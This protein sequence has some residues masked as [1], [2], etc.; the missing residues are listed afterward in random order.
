MP[1]A[2]VRRPIRVQLLLGAHFE[3]DCG[4]TI[5]LFLGKHELRCAVLWLLATAASIWGLALRGL[6]GLLFLATQAD[7]TPDEHH[8]LQ[9][10]WL[11]RKPPQFLSGKRDCLAAARNSYMTNCIRVSPRIVVGEDSVWTMEK[12]RLLGCGRMMEITATDRYSTKYRY[13]VDG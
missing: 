4:R 10:A 8:L 2:V 6:F 1:Q 11:A 5:C 9:S 7:A 3:L 12:D 13:G